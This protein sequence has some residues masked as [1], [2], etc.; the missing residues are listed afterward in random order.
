MSIF[1][2][3]MYM[4]NEVGCKKCQKKG[5][6][7]THWVMVILSFYILFTSVYGTIQLFKLLFSNI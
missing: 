7:G 2:K 4:E 1:K 3:K 6:S 5:L